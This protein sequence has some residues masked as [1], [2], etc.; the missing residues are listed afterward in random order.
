M[1][2]S[3]FK[4]MGRLPMTLHEEES[5]EDLIA[6][7]WDRVVRT[8]NKLTD[9]HEKFGFVRFKEGMNPSIE[10]VVNA[11]KMID[12]TFEVL[13]KSGQLDTNETRQAL[14]CRQC[15][16]HMKLLALSLEADDQDMYQEAI[17]LLTNQAPI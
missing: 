13:I 11:F 16:N 3:S 6:K 17:D 14:N 12:Q 4:D 2:V 15:I 7:V 5:M 9:T 8:C 1:A 10:V